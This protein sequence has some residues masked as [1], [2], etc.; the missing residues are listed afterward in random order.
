LTCEQHSSQKLELTIVLECM[1]N[2]D[3]DHGS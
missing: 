1:E 3:M 2:H